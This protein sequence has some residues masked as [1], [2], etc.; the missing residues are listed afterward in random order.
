MEIC[1]C[2]WYLNCEPKSVPPFFSLF[3][4]FFV[5]SDALFFVLL[6]DIVLISCLF[7]FVVKNFSKTQK[8]KSIRKKQRHFLFV[9]SWSFFQLQVCSFV[10]FCC[11]CWRQQKEKH[12]G[13]HNQKNLNLII[14][15][16]WSKGKQ[17]KK[18][19]SLRFVTETKPSLEIYLSCQTGLK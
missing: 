7:V 4:L 11:Y 18:S 5:C 15:S 14:V 13:C 19:Q 8:K 1:S 12:K 9:G 17:N 16:R 10:C 6:S 2:G 3:F